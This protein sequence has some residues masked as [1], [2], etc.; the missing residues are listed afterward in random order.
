MAVAVD[1]EDLEHEVAAGRRVVMLRVPAS[2]FHDTRTALYK[3][4]DDP[5]PGG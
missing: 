4:R 2:E 1:G 3:W 5:S